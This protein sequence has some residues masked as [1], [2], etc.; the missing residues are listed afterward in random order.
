MYLKQKSNKIILNSII[1]KNL[2]LI[3]SFKLVIEALVVKF[4]LIVVENLHMFMKF[5]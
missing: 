2:C 3:K 4:I 5:D 1:E